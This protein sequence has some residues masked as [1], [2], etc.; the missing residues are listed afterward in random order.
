[1]SDFGLVFDDQDFVLKMFFDEAFQMLINV[2]LFCDDHFDCGLNTRILCCF[3][4]E[5][6]DEF[7]CH[8]VAIKVRSKLHGAKF[9]CTWKASLSF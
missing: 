2:F 9:D 6:E 3:F 8:F 5:D 7:L 1:M 4:L